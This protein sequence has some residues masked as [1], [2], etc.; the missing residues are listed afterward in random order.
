MEFLILKKMFV[1]GKTKIEAD[2]K[3][4]DNQ[5]QNPRLIGVSSKGQDNKII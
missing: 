4:F 5:N 1:A 2:K 3:I